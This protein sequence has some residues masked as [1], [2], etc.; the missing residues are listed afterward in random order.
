MLTGAEQRCSSSCLLQVVV[1][2]VACCP[3]GGNT[4]SCVYE[5][6][7]YKLGTADTLC[8]GSNIVVSVKRRWLFKLSYLK[9]DC[10]LICSYLPV[11]CFQSLCMDFFFQLRSIHTSFR[12]FCSLHLCLPCPWFHEHTFCWCLHMT[13]TDFFLFDLICLWVKF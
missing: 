4:A 8:S 13:L 9:C 2:G 7:M 3:L 11:F 12:L 10:Y 5:T 1:C 6:D